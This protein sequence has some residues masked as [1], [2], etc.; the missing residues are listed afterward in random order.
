M[1]LSKL[2]AA[3][4]NALKSG[5]KKLAAKTKDTLRKKREWKPSFPGQHR[6]Y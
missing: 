1:G 6:G 3:L 5:D 4:Q 2:K